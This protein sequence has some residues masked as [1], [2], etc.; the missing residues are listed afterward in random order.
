MPDIDPLLRNR[1]T[2]GAAA[3]SGGRTDV[4]A[5]RNRGDADAL[6]KEPRRSGRGAELAV[7]I[8]WLV[9]GFAAGV[10]VG[11]IWSASVISVN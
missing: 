8:L 3:P 2:A 4:R 6:S 11:M 5:E 1:N 10:S 9:L 7:R